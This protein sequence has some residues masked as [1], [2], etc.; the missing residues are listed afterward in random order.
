MSQLF[1]QASTNQTTSWL[2]CG[3]STIGTRISHGHT[4][5]HK[6]H[7]NSDLEEATTFPLIVFSMPGHEGYTQMSFCLKTPKLGVPKFP[8][9]G[10]M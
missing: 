10:L 2:V 7:H 8:K 5:I 1:T 9:L 6:T 3:Y 4:W